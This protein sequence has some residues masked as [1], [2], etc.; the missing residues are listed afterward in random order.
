MTEQLAHQ[1]VIR[2]EAGEPNGQL[3]SVAQARREFIEER[4]KLIRDGWSSD[5]AHDQARIAVMKYRRTPQGACGLLHDSPSRVPMMIRASRDK[6]GT[7]FCFARYT[8]TDAAPNIPG[9]NTG[10]TTVCSAAQSSHR[11]A[12]CILA[13][14][15]GTMVF[16]MPTT[17]GNP[18]C[19]IKHSIVVTG[20]KIEVP[21]CI[22]TG[23][24]AR[25][26]VELQH[27]QGKTCVEVYSTSRTDPAHRDEF[28]EVESATVVCARRK[29]GIVRPR[30]EIEGCNR[31]E[32]VDRC[33][34]K[35][36]ER[37]AAE[38]RAKEEAEAARAEQARQRLE[39]QQAF[40]AELEEVTDRLTDPE[41]RLADFEA[42]FP[43]KAKRS[44]LLETL[45]NRSA[46]LQCLLEH[47]DPRRFQFLMPM[48]DK[49]PASLPLG[50]GH[51]HALVQSH[52]TNPL[53]QVL[54]SPKRLLTHE[55]LVHMEVVMAMSVEGLHVV[56][57][58][59]LQPDLARAKTM[60]ERAAE[61]RRA[62][63]LA[64]LYQKGFTREK[65]GDCADRW[66]CRT[67]SASVV[68]CL[69]RMG[70]SV[71]AG[72][73]M[74]LRFSSVECEAFKEYATPA[75]LTGAL[76]QALAKG[77]VS[78]LPI[79]AMVEMGADLQVCWSSRGI[80]VEG[81]LHLLE[82]GVE[83]RPINGAS[84]FYQAA[85]CGSMELADALDRAN[86]AWPR[87]LLA[88]LL[89]CEKKAVDE[90]RARHTEAMDV[91]ELECQQ[92]VDE[93][94]YTRHCPRRYYF[95]N[96]PT[97]ATVPPHREMAAHL[98][99]MG[100]PPFLAEVPYATGYLYPAAVAVRTARAQIEQRERERAEE[101]QRRERVQRWTPV[102]EA[103]AIEQ[104]ELKFAQLHRE[105]F[106]ECL[107]EVAAERHDAELK[108]RAAAA[109][110]WARTH[111]TELADR[112]A[113]MRLYDTHWNRP[114][115][116][117]IEDYGTYGHDDVGQAAFEAWKATLDEASAKARVD[118][119]QREAYR[120]KAEAQK[121]AEEERR[122]QELA[123][124]L[125]AAEAIRRAKSDA[126]RATHDLAREQAELDKK[127]RT[128]CKYG[129]SIPRVDL[130][131][132]DDPERSIL[133][134]D[135]RY[136]EADAKRKKTEAMLACHSE[137]RATAVPYKQMEKRKAEQE[138]EFYFTNKQRK[139]VMY[140][141]E[142]GKERELCTPD[143][144][145]WC[146][147]W[148]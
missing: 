62:D 124:K 100:W 94:G 129:I 88:V 136:K 107:R 128:I 103:L 113:A 73:E 123:A 50:A 115:Y 10:D 99:K 53:R 110:E 37:E 67:H 111:A 135:N 40:N 145:T 114:Y 78:R 130:S 134:L 81:R 54:K 127:W 137:A 144:C 43:D 59:V 126:W 121:H 118:Q 69:V 139:K 76:G 48:L 15:R 34:E 22:S 66:P 41:Y 7:M 35:K 38:A 85:K 60:I 58:Q 4:D 19:F 21:V 23:Y 29:V 102:A 72:L 68:G 75:E 146:R 143:R 3:L 96:K 98:M 106:A 20:G 92:I 33:D 97:R 64:A 13:D 142:F 77:S 80:G 26:D 51:V 87:N 84:A 44:R 131:A 133:N 90:A 32:C 28:I 89:A 14:F 125:D 36:R 8:G 25:L 120:L 105:V 31:W 101:Q 148:G 63:L 30:M 57:E 86:A 70:Y 116:A 119:E 39:K 45:A 61:F 6:R 108:A 140:L 56:I 9:A 117:R 138:T 82:K 79:H 1:Y 91:Y 18:D 132:S 27:T 65:V 74:A 147:K 112:R 141:D 42:R 17:C 49:R 109:D 24:K 83:P 104:L 52:N 5:D 93:H 12:Q 2:V 46:P 11:E 95:P 55:R 71:R 122:R 16:K 47:T